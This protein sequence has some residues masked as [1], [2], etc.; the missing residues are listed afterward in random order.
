MRSESTH[1]LIAMP[2]LMF[3]DCGT[4][5]AFLLELSDV[6]LVVIPAIVVAGI[7]GFLITIK[8]RCPACKKWDALEQTGATRRDGQPLSLRE[9]HDH[10]GGGLFSRYE[11]ERKCKYCDHRV[12]KKQEGS[13]YMEGG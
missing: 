2:Q 8:N 4:V 5:A 9:R 11:H 10:V 13:G 7:I 6:L 1:F 12:W 3:T